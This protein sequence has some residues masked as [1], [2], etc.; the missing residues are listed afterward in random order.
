M[1]LAIELSEVQEQ[2]LAAM[3]VRMGVLAES[4]AEAPVRDLVDRTSAEF[5]EVADQMLAKN[6][7]PSER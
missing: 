1:K 6:R 2:R 7:D 5:D 3:A 4:L